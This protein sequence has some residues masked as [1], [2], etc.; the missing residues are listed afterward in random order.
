LDYLSTEMMNFITVLALVAAVTAEIAVEEDVLVLTTAN[1]DEAV[2]DNEFMLVEFYAPWCGHCKSLAPEYAKAAGQLKADNSAIKL[3]KV[4]ATVETELGTKF[5]VQGYPTLKF[6]RKGSPS[7]YG[8]GRTAPEIVTWLNKKTGPPAKAIATEDELKAF[9][10]SAEVVLVGFFADAESEAAKAFLDAAAAVDDTPCGIV[11]DAAVAA[12]KD[13]KGDLVVLFKKFDEG[14]N[15]LAVEGLSADKVKAHISENSL[16]LGV[17]FTQET[18]QKIFGGDAKNHLLL[19]VSKASKEF[20]K[21]LADYKGAAAGFKGKVLFIFVDIDNAENDRILEF[22]G[23]KKEE[24]PTVRL[25]NLGEDMTKYKPDTVNLLPD[26]LTAFAQ[27]FLDG[28]LKPFLMSEEIPEDWDKTPVK[29]LVG[30]NF[31][32]VALD[33]K[34]AVLVEFYA[35]WCGHCKSLA[36]IWDELGEKYKDHESI[37]IAKMD[38]TANELE[39]VKVHSFPTIKYFPIGDGAEAVDFNGARTLEGF[40]KFLDA[41]GAAGN[42][43]EAGG[44]EEELG[45]D[46]EEEVE[47]EPS[48]KDEL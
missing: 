37:V 7:E 46:E 22:F 42:E 20:E 30:K 47:P 8:G 27:A 2:K 29:V 21:I 17:E 28:K 5:G 11:S 25:I 36:P 13:V 23:L 39:Q 14:R 1:F 34:K 15:D 19:F 6:F 9:I 33:A 41:G 10:E 3:A 38:A 18:A 4:D 32:Q 31:E 43:P 40:S 24:C 44:E 45:E 35:P 12:T 48:P 16:P 26:G